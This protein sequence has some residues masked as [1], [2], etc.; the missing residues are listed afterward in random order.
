MLIQWIRAQKN[1][2]WEFLYRVCLFLFS[3]LLLVRLLGSGG[4]RLGLV[5]IEIEND[6]EV[7]KDK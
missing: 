6:F 2:I 5:R 3:I 1:W 7:R 4:V